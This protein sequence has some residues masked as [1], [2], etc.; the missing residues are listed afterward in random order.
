MFLGYINLFFIMKE[1]NKYIELVNMFEVLVNL[2][3]EIFGKIGNELIFF[4]I[5]FRNINFNNVLV[6]LF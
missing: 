2:I 4:D 5:L 1:E 6:I 3:L